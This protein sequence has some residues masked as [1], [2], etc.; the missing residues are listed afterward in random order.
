M[1]ARDGCSSLDPKEKQE[2]GLQMKVQVTLRFQHTTEINTQ[3]RVVWG[4][5][6][7]LIPLTTSGSLVD[8]VDST[9]A[10]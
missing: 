2:T 6:D 3:H 8:C 7:A 1:V 10:T 9:Y 4:D 5:M